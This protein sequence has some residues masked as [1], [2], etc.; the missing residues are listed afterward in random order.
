MKKLLIFH[1]TV[2]PYR[3]DFFNHLCKAFETQVCLRYKNLRSQKLDYDRIA[4]LFAFTPVY[5]K[6][7]C[8]IGS[9]SISGEYWKYL[10]KFNPDIVF[11]EEFSI[12]AVIVLLHRFLKR[13][14]YKI[15][16]ICDDSYN[17]VAEGND[18][19]KVHKLSRKIL[20]PLIDS[21]ILV[22]SRTTEWYQENYGKGTWF[23][24]IKEESRSQTEYKE[25]LPLSNELAEKHGLF[26]KHVFLFVGRLVA[27]KNVE[28]IIKAFSKLDQEKNV[29]A[30]VGDGPERNNLT[31]LARKLHAQVLFTGRLEGAA[32]CAWYNIANCFILA[33]FQEAFGA[34]TNE[35]LLAGCRALVSE[36]AGSACLIK[37]GM[38]GDVFAP[39]DIERLAKKMQAEAASYIPTCK[40][41]A[42]KSLMACSFQEHMEHLIA[43]LHSL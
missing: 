11:V 17:M 42:K 4:S 16:S 18:F 10:D 27:L 13:K 21:L 20:A 9:R 1:S 33:S 15:V 26:G 28:T 7:V 36:K 35:A 3:I 14:K 19:S 5:Q 22:D 41:T 31:E 30:I 39:F 6:E 24:L 34:V 25:A 38:N 12:G 23:P 8:K 29:L 2:A 37:K 43:H 40:I 32:L